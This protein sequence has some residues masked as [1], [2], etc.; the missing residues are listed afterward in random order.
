MSAERRKENGGDR[1]NLK[2]ENGGDRYNL[3][4]GKK[5]GVMN[6]SQILNIARRRDTASMQAL[7]PYHP[8]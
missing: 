3:K 7:H 2:K 6:C 8:V 5:K 1:Y 4:K